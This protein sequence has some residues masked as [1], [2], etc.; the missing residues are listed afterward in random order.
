VTGLD[1]F[2]KNGLRL[3]IFDVYGAGKFLTPQN[4][5][6]KIKEPRVLKAAKNPRYKYSRV[7]VSSIGDLTMAESFRW[8]GVIL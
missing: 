5:V 4:L 7:W 8:K 3:T 6:M 2:N 1:D